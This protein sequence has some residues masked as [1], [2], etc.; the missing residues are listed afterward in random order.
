MKL[1]SAFLLLF[2]LVFAEYEDGYMNK[3]EVDRRCLRNETELNKEIILFEECKKTELTVKWKLDRC[4]FLDIK[5]NASTYD[6]ETNFVVFVGAQCIVQVTTILWNGMWKMWL[7]SHNFTYYTETSDQLRLTIDG[8]WDEIYIGDDRGL[9]VGCNNYFLFKTKDE[10]LST[11]IGIEVIDPPK[12]SVNMK[13]SAEKYDVTTEDILGYFFNDAIALEAT[14]KRSR[15][16][17][18]FYRVAINQV[19]G[20]EDD[21]EKPDALEGIRSRSFVLQVDLVLLVLV[22]MLSV[23]LG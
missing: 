6:D 12:F 19:K 15:I 16:P 2:A 8:V 9:D 5:W 4:L 22:S 17:N 14:S 13:V 23:W 1:L 21:V 11:K 3:K 20:D 10:Q 18:T 7:R